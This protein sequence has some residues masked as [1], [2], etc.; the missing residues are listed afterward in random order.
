MLFGMVEQTWIHVLNYLFILKNVGLKIEKKN[1][2]L[3]F[4]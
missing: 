3:Y 2:L 4:V 1:I